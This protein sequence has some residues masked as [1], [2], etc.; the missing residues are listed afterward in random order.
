MSDDENIERK[1]DNYIREMEE[2]KRSIA[3]KK[4]KE[5]SENLTQSPFNAG[6]IIKPEDIKDYEN[7]ANYWGQFRGDYC[8]LRDFLKAETS[9]KQAEFI[10]KISKG[11]ALLVRE[12][13][14]FLWTFMNDDEE[15][16]QSID[17]ALQSINSIIYD[18]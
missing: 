1:L 7:E 2:F 15:N 8:D 4:K 13:I 11:R 10:K 18:E 6:T 17:D 12:H 16:F 5:M 14:L 9:E 3:E